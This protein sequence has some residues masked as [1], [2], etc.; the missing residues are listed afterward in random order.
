[1]ELKKKN[2]ADLSRYHMPSAD[3]Q[4]KPKDCIILYILYIAYNVYPH[5]VEDAQV[6]ERFPSV[7]VHASMPVKITF[8]YAFIT[9]RYRFDAHRYS[10]PSLVFPPEHGV[11]TAF[12]S[13]MLT[14]IFIM[15][16]YIIY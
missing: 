8:N 13:M 11:R 5:A 1:M 2:V 7:L 6:S 16:Y 4:E 15:L 9:K 10:C 14:Y 12:C 3:S